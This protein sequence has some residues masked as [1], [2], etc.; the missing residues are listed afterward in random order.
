MSE[1]PIHSALP[2][3][4]QAIEHAS[5]CILQAPPGAGKT[6]AV[7]L[8]LLDLLN[9]NKLSG[10]ILMLEPRRL[11]ARS[12]A[13]RM[14]Q[15]LGENVGQT[16]GY[17]V[18]SDRKSSQHTRILVVT[19]GILTR[20][21]QADPELTGV[22]LVIFDEFHERSLHADLSLALCLQSQSA[23]REDLKLLIMS[24]T[25]NTEALCQRLPDA[26]VIRSEGR[27]YPI[28]Q[29]FWPPRQAMPN[30]HNL[31]SHTLAST[32]SAWQQH[33]GSILVFLPGVGEIKQLATALDKE[34]LANTLIAP[35]YGEMNKQAQDQAI[36]P[37]PSGQ[38]KI[39]LAT[40]IAETSIT[41]DGIT[42]VVDTG[43]A[44]EVEFA[45]S[46]GMNRLVTKMISRDSAEQR[47]GRAGRL[48]PGV[49]YRLW[50][51]SQHQ[52]LQQHHT[53]EILSSDL[54]PLVLEA[55]HWGA[56]SIDEFDW[57]DPPPA[58][59][60]AQAQDLLQQLG[61]IEP[62]LHL[63]PHGQGIL[64]LGLH[65]RLAHMLVRSLDI[66][67]SEEA[68]QLAA[69]LSERDI[70]PR[71]E[72]NADMLQRLS[73]LKRGTAASN[74]AVVKQ[75]AKELKTK[76]QKQ[77]ALS[78]KHVDPAVLLAH[79]YPERIAQLRN[80]KERR[81]RL[82]SGKGAVLHPDDL[83]P[84]TDYI[85]VA[86][87]D[88]RQGEAAIFTAAALNLEDIEQHFAHMIKEQ[89]DIAWD[90]EKQRVTAAT[91]RTLGAIQLSSRALTEISTE[92]VQQALLQGIRIRGLHC[93]PWSKEAL[94]LR[95]RVNFL[96]RLS[97]EDEYSSIIDTQLP[98]MDDEYLLTHLEEWLL[99]H[100]L[101]LGTI[102]RLD[103]L[104]SLDL[105]SILLSQMTWSEQQSL[106][107]LA[108]RHF[109]VP[110]G[111]RIAIDYSAEVPV[112]A[113]RLQEM[114]GAQD[115]PSILQGRYPLLIHLLSPAQRPMQITQ[116][117]YSFW[118]NTY[119]DVKKELKIKYK[120][121]YWPD[122]PLDAQ[123]TS[124]TKKNMHKT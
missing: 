43:L 55:A 42:V 73:L 92:Q 87:L 34:A 81:Y 124:K 85:V 1:L 39:V 100:L 114:F 57:I 101:H 41:I 56:Q 29:H 46:T 59:S 67:S 111:S 68:C 3:L 113:V 23:L 32:L 94:H 99:P 117:L 75:L 93:L 118:Q 64:S 50:T 123:A 13:T 72:R 106:E 84:D 48:A 78:S 60:V 80:I 51:E 14:A 16:V 36:S 121:H 91:H 74:S 66:G 49:C 24:A 89:E 61:A 108:P 122:N 15:L 5:C 20:M 104:K 109:T 119:Q 90:D 83:M 62:P 9:E 107:Q 120:K 26:P 76:L 25:L 53:P 8:A 37:P 86:S 17:Q 54:A 45:P 110:S 44:R 82:A 88:A 19:E 79:A 52:Q 58:S 28:E 102:N 63:T 31:I 98:A 103:K 105:H 95:K 97:T 7:P 112:L 21:L 71:G 77:G 116:D 70:L 10:N 18:R 96:N 22:A 2:E 33:P 11:A 69:L 4:I 65:P 35:L 6:T 12:S 38:R 115:T 30:R 40:N 27:S 47:S